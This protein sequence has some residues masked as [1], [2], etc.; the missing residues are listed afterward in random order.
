MPILRNT[1]N[2][3]ILGGFIMNDFGA[4]D[5]CCDE[6][7]ICERAD[8]WNDNAGCAKV[9]GVF[10]ATGYCQDAF[11]PKTIIHSIGYRNTGRLYRR[12]S[13][14]LKRD[15]LMHI[16]SKGT[17]KPHAGYVDYDWVDGVWR[18]VGTH[19]KYPANSR[20]QRWAKKETSK[21][22]RRDDIPEKGNSYRKVFDYW[23]TMY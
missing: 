19:I 16:I 3:I 15:R 2:H 6:C 9:G 17:Y 14:I 11:Q 7:S 13:A 23:N 8:R 18:Q 1:Q 12:K 20:L 4:S 22:V 21:R 10:L 5:S